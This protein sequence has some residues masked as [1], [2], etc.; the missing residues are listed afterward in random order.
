MC[1]CM[2]SKEAVPALHLH[3]TASH[4]IRRV[5]TTFRA[6]KRCTAEE[7]LQRSILIAVA[8]SAGFETQWA[9]GL[10]HL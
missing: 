9:S 1:M 5:L 4:N 7:L 3:H 10:Q 2:L 6:G 8:H